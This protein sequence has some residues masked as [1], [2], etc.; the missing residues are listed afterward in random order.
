MSGC[1][2]NTDDPARLQGQAEAAL[3]RWAD[4][5]AAAGGPSPVIVVGERTG[6]AGD[7]EPAVGDNNKPALM[8]GLVEAGPDL[9]GGAQPDGVVTW[10][11]GTTASVGVIS[12]RQAV[13]AIQAGSSGSCGECQPLR[14]MAARLIAGPIETS[15]GPATAPVW[16]LT[17]QGTAVRITRDAIA[18]AAIVVAP[19]WNAGEPSVG[20]AIDAASGTA[21][22]R[23]LTVS[24]TGAPLPGDRPCGED[25]TARAVESDLAVV[26][27][28]TRHPHL[29]FGACT[30]EGAIRSATAELAAPLGERAVLDVV[31]GRPG[32]GRADA[33]MGGLAQRAGGRRTSGRAVGGHPRSR[34]QPFGDITRDQPPARTSGVHGRLSFARPSGAFGG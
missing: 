6:Q 19:A 16:E 5:V 8:A 15:R 27:I 13:A 14:I 28:V 25:Y 4:A 10:P 2:G 3:A 30:T 33:V 32:A 17:V 23:E 18:N 1:V 20:L 29:T 22:G 34:Q 11:D 9:P 24:F 31:Q 26:V 12:A 21:G 7:W